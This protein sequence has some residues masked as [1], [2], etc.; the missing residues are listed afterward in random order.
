[1]Q[2]NYSNQSP[3]ALHAAARGGCAK[4]SQLYPRSGHAQCDIRHWLVLV[5]N[6]TF[7]HTKPIFE[8]LKI[9]TIFDLYT[10]FNFTAT[11]K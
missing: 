9:L 1:M 8:N 7:Q 4:L 10:Y 11:E 3:L 6:E 5:Q 2:Y